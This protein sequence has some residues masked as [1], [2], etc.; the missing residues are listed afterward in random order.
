ELPRGDVEDRLLLHLVRGV[1]DD[2]VEPAERLHSALDEAL[3]LARQARGE[4]DGQAAAAGALD[5]RERLPRVALFL[6]REI[7]DGHVVSCPREGYR[8]RPPDPAG[9]AGDDGGEVLQFAAA[10]IALLAV[11][12]LGTHGALG[13]G[14]RLPRTRLRRLLA[15]LR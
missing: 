11:V 6:R 10:A 1:V 8:H 13:T 9:A 15:A 5:P 7:A 3:A 4:A 14:H 2:D 12:R